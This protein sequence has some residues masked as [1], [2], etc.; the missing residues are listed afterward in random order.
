MTKEEFEKLIAKEGDEC[1]W[2]YS[3]DN[4]KIKCKIIRHHSMK[5]L[6][7]YVLVDK[8]NELYKDHENHKDNLSVHGGITFD[9]FIDGDFYIGFDC[10]HFGDLTTILDFEYPI[11]R[12]VYR[13]KEYVIKETERLAKQIIKYS[14][15]YKRKRKLR[16]IL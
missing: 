10:A 5:H 11:S 3:Y 15:E 16:E 13:D 2:I 12:H 1:E 8:N 4:V 7:G 6:C 9:G 14:K